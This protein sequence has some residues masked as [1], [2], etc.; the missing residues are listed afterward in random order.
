MDFPL[1]IWTSPLQ[2]CTGV[3]IYG[4]DFPYMDNPLHS[5]TQHEDLTLLSTTLSGTGT[6]SR[7]GWF[8]SRL[9]KLA[10][11]LV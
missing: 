3:S 2:I 9:G 1:H 4:R 5:C 10:I 6:M 11:R 8:T 7:L